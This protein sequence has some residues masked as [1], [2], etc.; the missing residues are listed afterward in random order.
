MNYNYYFIFALI[1]I[2]LL[3]FQ[4]INN[5]LYKIFGFFM[6]SYAVTNL[7]IRKCGLDLI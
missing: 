6:F 7:F 4:E 5:K 1:F 3:I 2:I